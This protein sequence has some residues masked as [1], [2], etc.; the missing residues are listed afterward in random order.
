MILSLRDADAQAKD[1]VGP[2]V[3]SGSQEHGRIGIPQRPNRRCSRGKRVPHL[4]WKIR[5]LAHNTSRDEANHEACGGHCLQVALAE[6]NDPEKYEAML[7][8]GNRHTRFW[9]EPK[10][11][12]G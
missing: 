7:E 2:G 11:D 9:D 6:T 1:T 3:G 8:F 5:I 4:R 10:T 12:L